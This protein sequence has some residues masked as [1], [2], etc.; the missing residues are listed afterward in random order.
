MADAL[1]LDSLPDEQQ[2][3]AAFLRSLGFRVHVGDSYATAKAL[4]NER[5]YALLLMDPYLTRADDGEYLLDWADRVGKQFALVVIND[6]VESP[7]MQRI[8]VSEMRVILTM[9]AKDFA[10]RKVEIAAL[11]CRKNILKSG[12]AQLASS[13]GNIP[14]PKETLSVVF[15][16]VCL[17]GVILGYRWFSQHLTGDSFLNTS[18]VVLLVLIVCAGSCALFGI[19]LREVAKFLK[20]IF[21]KGLFGL[22]DG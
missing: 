1:V 4:L 2:E 21:P 13:N 6:L 17:I 22:D 20:S 7:M 16:L 19:S 3:Y 9:K 14:G 18:S 15:A 8:F 10:V 11:V 12:Q 5:E